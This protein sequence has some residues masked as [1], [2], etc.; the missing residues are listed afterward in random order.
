MEEAC[1]TT[2]QKITIFRSCFTG[3]DDIYGT[4]DP[5]TSRA[6]QMKAPVTDKVLLRHLQGI[7]PYGVYLLCGDRTGAVVADF[8][9][10]DSRA[11]RSAAWS[12]DWSGHQLWPSALRPKDARRRRHRK[13]AGGVFSFGSRLEEGRPASGRRNC[14]SQHMGN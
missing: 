12:R 9:E 5:A 14:L 8:D 3:R 2:Q 6:W 4:Y 10:E 11:S 13:P 7:Q 1:L